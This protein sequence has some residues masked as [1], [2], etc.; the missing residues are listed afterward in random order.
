MW[1]SGSNR[2]N[3]DSKTD[4]QGSSNNFNNKNNN[5]VKKNLSDIKGESKYQQY[6]N[7]TTKI[8]AT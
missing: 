2:R 6:H 5:K 3:T 4:H 8:M 7:L 1:Y